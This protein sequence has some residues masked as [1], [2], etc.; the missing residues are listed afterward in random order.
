MN[1]PLSS[2]RPHDKIEQLPAH[3]VARERKNVP[4]WESANKILLSLN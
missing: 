3:D 4:N 2:T 1:L